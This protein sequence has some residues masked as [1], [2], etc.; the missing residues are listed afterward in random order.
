MERLR[1]GLGEQPCRGRA[2]RRAEV[3][4]AEHGRVLVADERPAEERPG[5]SLGIPLLDRRADALAQ[6]QQRQGRRWRRRRCGQRRGMRGGGEAG[7]GRR[8]GDTDDRDGGARS[9]LFRDAVAEVLLQLLRD[10]GIPQDHEPHRQPPSIE[11]DARHQRVLELRSLV[12]DA[13][14]L[15]ARAHLGG[16]RGERLLQRKEHSSDE[17]DGQE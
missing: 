17:A 2:E 9:D 10:S 6:L 7:D 15:L 8:V 16:H 3:R 1:E 14:E 5:F 11:A 12:Q 13:G 4:E